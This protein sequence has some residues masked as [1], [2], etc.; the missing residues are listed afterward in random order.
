MSA[1]S[2]TVQEDVVSV[3]EVVTPPQAV[4]QVLQ[5]PAPTIIEVATVTPGPQGPQGP[6]G[7]PG[8]SS[9]N[10]ASPLNY[11]SSTNTLTLDNPLDN[12]ILDAGNF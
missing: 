3:T 7:A 8:V 6:S 1:Y 11:D 5:T 2:I 12:E 10:V 9:I 4:I